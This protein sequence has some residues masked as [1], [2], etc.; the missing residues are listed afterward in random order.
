MSDTQTFDIAVVGA[1]VVG[2]TTALALASLG[3]SIALLDKP[4]KVDFAAEMEFDPRV[5]AIT[6]HSRNFFDELDAWQAMVSQRVSP[7]RQ[8]KV[9]DGSGNGKI[10]FAA[11]DIAMPELGYIVEQRVILQALNQVV[12]KQE[13]IIRLA[14]ANALLLRDESDTHQLT[15]DDG[16]QIQAQLIVAADGANSW[17]RRQAQI[18]LHQQDYGHHAI[19]ATVKTEQPHASTAY[20]R[21]L[22]TGP[23]AFLPLVEPSTSS[24]VWSQDS[25]KAQELFALE[26]VKFCQQLSQGLDYRLGEIVATSKRYI[27]PLAMRHAKEYVKTGIVLVGDA[28]HTVHPLAGQ[29]VNLGLLDAQVLTN[30]LRRISDKQRSIRR[31][32]NLRRYERERK[33]HNWL[34]IAA[35]DGF[36]RLFASS[37]PGLYWLRNSGL[38]ACDAM[39]WMKRI[40][41]SSA[42][43]SVLG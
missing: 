1:G 38:N 16:S 11:R 23:L 42:G 31:K 24:I 32:E 27:F 4:A 8:M 3:F 43:S 25:E 37:N 10:E 30:C 20:Q 12:A 2:L 15:L 39:G 6:Q 26:D 28:A 29:G 22:P 41:M 18:E 36:K 17:V 19:V 35:M 33:S 21:F 34:M 9:W 40:F 13:N 5:F 14:A 7:Y